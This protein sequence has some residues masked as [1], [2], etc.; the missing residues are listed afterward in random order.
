MEKSKK[1]EK[2][3]VCL[4]C[5]LA[6]HIKLILDEKGNVEKIVG[7]RCS[8]GEE[9]ALKEYRSPERV[10]TAT[11]R[12]NKASHPLLSVRTNRPIPKKLLRQCMSLLAEVKVDGPVKMGEV[13]LHNILNTGVDV[14]ATQEI[15]ENEE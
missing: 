3:I 8:K 4:V 5:P 12:T 9:Y 6:C 7:A 10:L 11:V 13:I 15:R 14:I 1:N 2:T